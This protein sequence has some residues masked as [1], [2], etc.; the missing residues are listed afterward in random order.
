MQPHFL[1]LALSVRPCTGGSIEG[2]SPDTLLE[3][4]WGLQE[5]SIEAQ[6]GVPTLQSPVQSFLPLQPEQTL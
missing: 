1:P 5:E 2:S 6:T 4:L 3:G